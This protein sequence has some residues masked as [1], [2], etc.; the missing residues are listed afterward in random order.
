MRDKK[1]PSGAKALIEIIRCGTAEAVPFLEDCVLPPTLKPLRQLSLAV[2]S[3]E[4][5]DCAPGDR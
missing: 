1:M 4:G 5:D 2:K 3:L